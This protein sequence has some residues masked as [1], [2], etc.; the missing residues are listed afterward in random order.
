MRQVNVSIEEFKRVCDSA[1]CNREAAQILGLSLT[2]F[3]KRCKAKGI[4]TPG[5]R[6][7]Q[8]RG[9]NPAGRNWKPKVDG[10]KQPPI[11]RYTPEEYAALRAA[12]TA[13]SPHQK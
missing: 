12:E 4:Q 8:G 5:Q 9:W 3:C 1:S 13:R 7:G 11:K 10:P 6:L 2:T